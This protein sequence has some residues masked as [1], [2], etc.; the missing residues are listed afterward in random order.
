M[1][2]RPKNKTIAEHGADALID[3]LRKET[4]P[5]ISTDK[6]TADEWIK[7]FLS[8]ETSPRAARLISENRPYSPKTIRGYNSI[9]KNH[10][11][12]DPFLKIKMADIEQPDVLALLNRIAN[13]DIYDSRCPDRK[14]K[15]ADRK[16]AGTRAFET[17][18]S[19][20]RMTFN[21]YQTMAPR[22]VNP[23]LSIKKPKPAEGAGR[24]P[25]TEKEI[26]LLFMPG[27]L[28]TTLERAV[29]AAMFWAGLRRGEI[30]GLKPE[31]LD[32]QTPK[33]N[34]EFAWKDY[35]SKD[36]IL[37]DPKHHKKRQAPFPEVLQQAIR[38][39]WEENGK[40]EFVFTRKDGSQPTGNWISENMK[41]W[42]QAAGIKTEGRN[43]SPHSSRHSLASLLEEKGVP[44]RYIQDLLGHSDL[45]TTKGYLHTAQGSIN[46]IAKEINA[47]TE[48]VKESA[49]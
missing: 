15:T 34:I 10:L 2:R 6:I 46:N 16:T 19:F 25:L 33:I 8:V 42:L 14:E 5:E 18:F 38:D 26:A 36:R 29:C 13:H 37:D 24:D 23:F 35:D 31:N 30:W 48:D 40:H 12:G 47:V 1:Y 28:K 49:N 3:F 21:E 22:W 9:Y 32:W 7:K 11:A 41:I 20:V 39:L 17:V 44:L 27:I 45:K 4:A 43:I